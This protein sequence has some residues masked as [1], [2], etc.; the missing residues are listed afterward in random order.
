M[1]FVIGIFQTQWKNS[2]R[3]H[4]LWSQYSVYESV[5][6]RFT[7]SY[8]SLSLYLFLVYGFEKK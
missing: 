3:C 1:V 7:I 8:H 6:L 2:A 5:A 4:Y